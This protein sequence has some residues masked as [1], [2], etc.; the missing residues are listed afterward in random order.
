MVSEYGEIPS[1][2]AL[3]IA[4]AAHYSN[5]D[6]PSAVKLAELRNTKGLEAVLTDVCHLEQGSPLFDR[7]LE[8]E[9]TLKQEGV[10]HA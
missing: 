10:L 4:A 1:S 5:P 6:D 7:I 8:S 3:V 9:K 2:L